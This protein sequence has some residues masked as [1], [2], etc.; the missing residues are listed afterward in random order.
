MKKFRKRNLQ[1]PKLQRFRRYRMRTHLPPFIS[2]YPS[3]VQATING[4]QV[5]YVNG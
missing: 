2:E 4:E 3:T 5:K 1:V